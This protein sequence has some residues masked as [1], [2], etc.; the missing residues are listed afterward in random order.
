MVTFLSYFC[1]LIFAAAADAAAVHSSQY[2]N[3]WMCPLTHTSASVC[4]CVNC[5]AQN[6]YACVKKTQKKTHVTVVQESER[7]E[8]EQWH[9]IRLEILSH[10]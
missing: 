2:N 4:G 9:E 7:R 8:N 1:Y 10:Y 5:V 3:K 6:I